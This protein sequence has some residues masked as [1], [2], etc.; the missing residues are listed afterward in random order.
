MRRLI[1]IRSIPEDGGYGRGFFLGALMLASLLTGAAQGPA[2]AQTPEIEGKQA[3]VEQAQARIQATLEDLSKAQA[4]Y[5]ESQT[6]LAR[7]EEDIAGNE[8]DLEETGE[9]LDAAKAKLSERS[10]GSY[11]SGGVMYLDVLLSVRSFSD[12]SSKGQFVLKVLERDQDAIEKIEEIEARL[13]DQRKDL[14][15]RKERQAEI[16]ARMREEQA[17][18]DERLA[19]QRATYD[20]L[21]A[22]VK[23]LIQEEQ[24]R[25]AREAAER[26]ARAE[27]I[28]QAEAER[29][30]QAEAD[31]A[32]RAARDQMSQFSGAS[33]EAS[34]EAE[35]QA[36]AEA[37]AR[38]ER[39]RLAVEA[40]EAEE[41][42]ADAKDAAEQ[43]RL[44]A[45][46][47]Q[48][49]QAAREQAAAEEAARLERERI[50]AEA[51]QAEEA[52]TAAESQYEEPAPGAPVSSVT[53]SDP[54]ARAILNNPNIYL[55]T[56]AQQD[57]AAGVVDARVLDV[58]EFA[59]QSHTISISVFS[60]GH[61]YGPTL[62]ALGYAGYPN[63]HYF[64]RAV[65]IYEVDGVAV[66]SG[67]AAAQ[68]LARAIFDN[69]APE[70]LG[71]PWIFGDGSFSDAIHQDHIHVGWPYGSDGG[72]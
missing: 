57:L 19:E 71:S 3:E 17:V 31:A 15:A 41:Q 47:E 34:A 59:A 49:R 37:E 58:L 67:N 50:V 16:S 7:V 55:T 52:A 30:A 28:A 69:F 46:A 70:E 10:V 44:A 35:R 43:R 26:R 60:T 12:L 13:A 11:K 45:E 18:I 5:N 32:A 48:A 61:P 24:A 38:R 53:S 1:G 25:Q 65:D 20:S 63:A 51:Q 27:A 29:Q 39:Q 14:E 62:D 72:L 9:E 42:A 21:S 23:Q 6:K 64:G 36:V 8:R 4:V 66:T 2:G 40:A 54:R 33:A 22:E 56:M 68:E